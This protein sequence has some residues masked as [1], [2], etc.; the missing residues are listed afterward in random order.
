MLQYIFNLSCFR[1]RFFAGACKWLAV[2]DL[3]A[4][5]SELAGNQKMPGRGVHI[6]LP[7][8]AASVSPEDCCWAGQWK[9]SSWSPEMCNLTLCSG[10]ES[11]ASITFVATAMGEPQVLILHVQRCLELALGGI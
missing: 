9:Q 3:N 8:F 6:L 11:V 1:E 5:Q 4:G 2:L 10:F 7:N